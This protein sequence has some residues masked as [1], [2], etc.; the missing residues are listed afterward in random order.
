MLTRPGERVDV[1]EP[2]ND[3]LIRQDGR[4]C[5]RIISKNIKFRFA[6]RSD[7]VETRLLG[8]S[9]SLFGLA[10]DCTPL[11]YSEQQIM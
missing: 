2:A 8:H 4:I 6:P 11:L 7:I 9:L 1:D 10:T 3:F 5:A